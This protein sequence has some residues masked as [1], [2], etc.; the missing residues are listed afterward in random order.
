MT[1]QNAIGLAAGHA[2]KI[3]ARLDMHKKSEKVQI[4]FLLRFLASWYRTWV[5]WGLGTQ[6]RKKICEFRPPN[7]FFGPRK[8]VSLLF[9]F[10]GFPPIFSLFDLFNL[11]NLDIKSITNRFFKVIKLNYLF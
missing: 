10:T 9:Y 6:I 8:V 2:A 3:V 7:A 11:F 1:H 4:L 5:N